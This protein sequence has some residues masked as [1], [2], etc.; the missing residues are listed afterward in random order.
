MSA[1]LL[2]TRRTALLG[3]ATAFTLGRASLALAQA[4]TDKRFVVFLLRGALDGMSAVQPYGDANCLALRGE[5]ALPAPG[6]AGGLLDLGGFYG[7]HPGLQNLHAMFAAGDALI[8]PAAAGHYRSRS[9]FEAQDF[10]E[11]GADQRLSSGWLNRAVTAMN[12]R[13]GTELALCMG[14]S[15]PLLLRGPARVAAWAPEHFGQAP[16]EE[17]FSRLLAI[18]AHDTVLGPALA[19]GVRQRGLSPGGTEAGRNAAATLASAAGKLLAEPGGPR[20]A[21]LELGGWDTHNAQVPRLKGQFAQLDEALGALQTGLGTAWRQT[22]ILVVTEFGRTAR[23]NG[24]AGTDHG[25]AGVAFVLGGAVA[26]GKVRG[27]W[28]GLGPGQL[29]ENRDLAPTTDVRAIAKGVLASHLGLEA[30]GLDAAF[31]GSNDAAPLRGLV[32]A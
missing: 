12:S 20:I 10:L 8:I 22:A 7:L 6:G 23:V 19:E 9:H 21:A 27:D 29:F 1:S 31:P 26:G 13:S 18:S 16:G 24:T 2:L 14:V 32:R 3:L 4:P 5:L 28:P 11:S 17:F 25:T 30:S 15:A